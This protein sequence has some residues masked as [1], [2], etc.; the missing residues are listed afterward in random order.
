LGGIAFGD[1]LPII[2]GVIVIVLSWVWLQ[3]VA[4]LLRTETSLPIK[5]V[6]IKLGMRPSLEIECDERPDPPERP[7]IPEM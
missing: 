2:L 4:Q 7:G 3:G 6:T 5:R 1:V